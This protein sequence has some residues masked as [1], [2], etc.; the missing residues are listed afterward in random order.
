[1]GNSAAGSGAPNFTLHDQDGRRVS[2]AG[3]R[4]RWTVVTFLYTRCPDVCPLIAS[5]L[6]GALRELGSTAAA[7]VRV[8]AVSVDPKGDT[9]AMVR[10]FIRKHRLLPEF[11][12]LT[13]TPRELAPIWRGYHVAAQV[14]P[15]DVS[16]HSAY[17]LLI[18]PT[19]APRLRYAADLQA[20]D[21]IHDLAALGVRKQAAP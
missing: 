14:G 5:Q 21:L 11:R 18:D 2:L 3:Q 1:M 10:W 6:N 4:G 8:L 12:Y 15:P 17:E 9:P 19:G 7:Q 16:L 13:G 20:R